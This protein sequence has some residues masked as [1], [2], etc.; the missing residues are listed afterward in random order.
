VP[1]DAT[2]PL[3]WL[4]KLVSERDAWLARRSG[5]RIEESLDRV[6]IFERDELIVEVWVEQGKI[7]RAKAAALTLA[8]ALDQNLGAR[9]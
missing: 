8:L 6:R 9:A 1:V 4:A 7:E 2:Q 5:R 3:S